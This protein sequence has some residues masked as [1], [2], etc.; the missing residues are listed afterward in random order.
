VNTFKNLSIVH[1]GSMNFMVCELYLRKEGG[2]NG[3]KEGRKEIDNGKGNLPDLASLI[4]G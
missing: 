2:K 3:R 1:F 4:L